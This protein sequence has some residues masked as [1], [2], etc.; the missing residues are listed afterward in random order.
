MGFISAAL[1]VQVF[2]ERNA[3]QLIFPRVKKEVHTS[4]SPPQTELGG[5]GPSV[6]VSLFSEREART[7]RLFS[8]ALTVQLPAVT[9]FCTVGVLVKLY[10]FTCKVTFLWNTASG[11]T[12]MRRSV[13]AHYT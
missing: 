6:V 12:P 10:T 7:R 2:D 5:V 3:K 1:P 11:L 9:T 4:F 8:L 13:N